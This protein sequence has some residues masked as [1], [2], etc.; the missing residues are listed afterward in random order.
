MRKLIL[1][2][3]TGLALSALIFANS[4]FAACDPTKEDTLI[5]TAGSQKT[6]IYL[7]WSSPINPGEP[8]L[9]LTFTGPSPVGCGDNAGGFA[10]TAFSVSSG[11]YGGLWTTYYNKIYGGTADWNAFYG[12]LAPP[13]G[14]TLT[15]C[16]PTPSNLRPK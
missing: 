5:F 3:L 4:A 9:S 13:S 1:P 15:V 11:V 7:S 16:I 10:C 6:I 8:P 12:T 2:T 14:S